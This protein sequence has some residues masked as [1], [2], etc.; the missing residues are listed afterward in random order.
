[1]NRIENPFSPGAGTPPPALVGRSALLEEIDT[2]V[3]RLKAGRSVQNLLLTGL[4]GVGK[5]V[6][7][8]EA[9]RKARRLAVETVF[10][11]ADE[12]KSLSA[13]LMSPLKNI[14]FDLDRMEGAKNAVRRGLVALR[15]FLGTVH[16]DVGPFGLDIEPQHGLADSGDLESDLTSLFLC[17]GEA[18][19]EKSTAVLLVVD[20]VQCLSGRDFGA[21]IMALHRMQQERLPLGMAGAGLP[22]LPNLA[23]TA[24]SY[25]E[26]LFQFPRVGALDTESCDE[27]VRCPFREAGVEVL[28]GA[29]ARVRDRTKG[30]PYFVQEWGYQLW[31]RASGSP[32]R[33]SDVLAVDEAATRRLDENFFRVRMERLTGG[34]R[35]FLRAMSQTGPEPVRIAAVAETLGV[36][37][38]ALSPR[39]GALIRKGMVYAPSHGEIAYTVP[40]FGEYLRRNPV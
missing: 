5:T 40:L 3:G 38:S 28:D 16:L 11:E 25:A 15:N 13:S 34:E 37:V 22:T 10:F 17:V 8:T 29:L 12:E 4:R 21:L 2:L 26:R 36:S 35:A 14:L 27:A 24:K 18:A 39:R 30:Y 32:V 7:L 6:L 31:N 19:A 20:E 33:E 9:R 23:G 1:M